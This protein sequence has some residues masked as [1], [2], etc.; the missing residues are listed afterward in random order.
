MTRVSSKKTIDSLKV[1]LATK[2]MYASLART[3]TGIDPYYWALV[4]AHVA[5]AY[6]FMEDQ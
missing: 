1:A 6:D 3:P 2:A 4:I 5:N